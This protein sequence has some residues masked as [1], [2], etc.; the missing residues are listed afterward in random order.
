[1]KDGLEIVYVEY[2]WEV[3]WF[4]WFDVEWLVDRK[5]VVV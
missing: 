4:V 3:I 5:G 2:I 1:M